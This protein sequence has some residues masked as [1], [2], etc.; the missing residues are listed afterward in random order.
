[1]I[2]VLGAAC[3]LAC[4]LLGYFVGKWVAGKEIQ[5]IRSEMDILDELAEESTREEENR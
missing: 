3:G 1:M 2:V 4:Y 5:Q